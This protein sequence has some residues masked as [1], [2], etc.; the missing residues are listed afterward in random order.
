MKNYQNFCEIFYASHYL[1]IAM[2]EGEHFVCASGFYEEGDPYP[3]VF[4]KMTGY[5]SPSVYVSSDMGYYGLVTCG[6]GLH[7]FVL[8]PAYSTPV[9]E[10]FIRSYIRKNM[11]PISRYEEVASL[12]AQH[13]PIHL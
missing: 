2:Y 12:S 13:S 10:E 7:A 9:T 11:L 1:P 4:S 8:G 3:F 5:K 6:D